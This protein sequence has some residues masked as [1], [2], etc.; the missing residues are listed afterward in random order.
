MV[1]NMENVEARELQM[2]EQYLEQFKQQV[3]AYS[4]QLEMLESRRMETATAVETLKTLADQEGPTVLLQIGGGASLRVH[5]PDTDTVLLNIGADVVV[6]RTNTET[7]D[8]L[9]ERMT[10]MEALAK[11]I[12]ESIEQV[13]KQ[14]HDVVRRMESTYSQA[15]SRMNPGIQG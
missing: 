8:Y 5:V 13:Q 12:A 4:G 7:V 1:N 11:K 14:A 9:E 2:L 3:E 10:E 6:E 15:Q